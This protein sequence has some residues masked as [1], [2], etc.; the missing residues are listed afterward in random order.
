MSNNLK[1]KYKLTPIIFVCSQY[2]RGDVQ[3]LKVVCEQAYVHSAASDSDF[4]FLA[5]R[6]GFRSEGVWEGL[7]EMDKQ[8]DL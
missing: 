7:G 3:T 6:K 1:S 4:S 5:W 8:S 2:L